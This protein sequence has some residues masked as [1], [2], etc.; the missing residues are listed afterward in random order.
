MGAP[1]L[2][3]PGNHDI[4]RFDLRARLTR[5]HAR[6]AALLGTEPEPEHASQD[7]RLL[8]VNTPRAGRPKNGEAAAARRAED[9][10]RDIR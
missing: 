5:P 7:L 8:G 3:I 6:C 1:V 2:A 10:S 4:A 9:G